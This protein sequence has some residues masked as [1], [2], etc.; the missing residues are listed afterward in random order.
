MPSAVTS[1]SPT[2]IGTH[3]VNKLPLTTEVHIASPN[4]TCSSRWT[5]P[6]YFVNLLHR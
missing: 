4:K 3:P 2:A 5:R 1:S 6:T